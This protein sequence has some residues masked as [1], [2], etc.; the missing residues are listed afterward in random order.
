MAVNIDTKIAKLTDGRRKDLEVRVA[1]LMLDEML[2]RERQQS[3]NTEGKAYDIL[4][5][6]IGTQRDECE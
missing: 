5:E 1:E 6:G 2:R 3:N 4:K